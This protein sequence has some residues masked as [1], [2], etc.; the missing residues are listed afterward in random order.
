MSEADISTTKSPDREPV[1]EILDTALRVVTDPVNFYR[2]MPTEGG[3]VQPLIFMVAM[4]VT[5]GLVQL[6]LGLIGLGGH[7]PVA[8]ALA[9][10]VM[11]PLMFLIFGFVSAAIVYVIWLLMG[12]QRNFE[13][14]YRCVAYSSAITPIGAVAGIIPYLGALVIPLWSAALMAIASIHVHAR[15]ETLSWLVFGALGAILAITNLSGEIAGRRLA[16]GL[17]A[18]EQQLESGEMTPEQAGQAVGEFLKGLQQTT[19]PEENSSR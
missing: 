15:K 4:G 3:F 1:R 17:G 19:E 16:S 12:S 14:A 11:A 9:A 10:P 13:T 2:H 18:L 6:L 7:V 5:T 8:M